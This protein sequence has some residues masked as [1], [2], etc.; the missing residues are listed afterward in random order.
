MGHLLGR[1]VKDTYDTVGAMLSSIAIYLDAND[2]G[3]GFYH[4]A[5]EMG[6]LPKNASKLTKERFWVDQMN[7]AIEYFREGGR[8]GN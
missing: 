1:I 5:Q 3:P 6:L 2:A 8:L 7:T 4:L